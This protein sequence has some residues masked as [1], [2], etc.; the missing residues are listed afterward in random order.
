M[1]SLRLHTVAQ[2]E[3]LHCRGTWVAGIGSVP[4]GPF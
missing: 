2:A 1:T 3:D 4:L